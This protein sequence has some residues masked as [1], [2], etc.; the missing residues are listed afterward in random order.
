MIIENVQISD[1]MLS[2]LSKIAE[3]KPQFD[4][5]EYLVSYIVKNGL[6][7]TNKNANTKIS[8]SNLSNEYRTA[9]LSLLPAKLSGY[10]VCPFHAHCVNDCIGVFSGMNIQPNAIKSK[11]AK[12]LYLQYYRE[13][14]IEI[15]IRE[16]NK[17]QKLCRKSKVL[18]A[19]RLNTYSDIL[20][21]RIFPIIFTEF[22]SIQ[23]YDYSKVYH[24]M[25]SKLPANYDLTYS[26]I[27]SVQNDFESLAKLADKSRL[28]IVVSRDIF[29]R[30]ISEL[31]ESE[32]L[33]V[34][35]IRYYN[36]DLDDMTFRY[37]N[38]KVILV[39]KEKSVYKINQNNL[40][41]LVYRNA[42]RLGL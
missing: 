16:I 18:P 6:L 11:L 40:N 7:T 35:D 41:P 42:K 26:A 12:T 4:D 23:F 37:P 33:K 39:L 3:I 31:N 10:N 9:N 25:H 13:N 20:W 29:E 19:I 24:R 30:Y 38:E 36:G 14:F 15:L 34:N 22:P 28:S 27:A 1:K 21:E 2:L 32:Y 8:K 17:F 5:R